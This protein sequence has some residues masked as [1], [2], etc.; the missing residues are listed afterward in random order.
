[1][2]AHGGTLPDATARLHACT[3]GTLS[4]ATAHPHACTWRDTFSC[5]SMLACMHMAGRSQ[6]QQHARMHAHGRTLPAA[7]ACRCVQ[8]WQGIPDSDITHTCS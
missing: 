6:L 2:H 7:T 4:T 1:M 8:A 3:C 5:K